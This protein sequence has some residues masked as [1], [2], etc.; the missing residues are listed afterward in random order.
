[1]ELPPKLPV[2]I[3]PEDNT[4][5]VL[6]PPKEEMAALVLAEPVIK[7]L[8]EKDTG[9]VAGFEVNVI[10]L[11]SELMNGTDEGMDIG[12]EN[13]LLPV[14]VGPEGLTMDVELATG[15]RVELPLFKTEDI[16]EEGTGD[17]LDAPEDIGSEPE[18]I[19][20]CGDPGSETV[21][22]IIPDDVM[23]DGMLPENCDSVFG[24][25]PVTA[26]VPEVPL[27]VIV[28]I[29]VIVTDIPDDNVIIVTASPVLAVMKVLVLSPAGL[30]PIVLVG[31]LVWPVGCDTVWPWGPL[32]IPAPLLVFKAVGLGTLPYFEVRKRVWLLDMRRVFREYLLNIHRGNLLDQSLA[33][34]REMV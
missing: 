16:P 27:V 25:L 19:V 14:D 4:E 8:L 29:T 34:W 31:A 13:E 23:I 6:E 1:M 24:L 22:F 5:P 21:T 33:H 32:P 28:W 11:A 26:A 17:A 18:N 20:L 9:I 3:I 10:E 12:T 7:L 15:L 30:V 2:V